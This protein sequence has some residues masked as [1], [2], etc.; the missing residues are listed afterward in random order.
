MSLFITWRHTVVKRGSRF[1][2][3]KYYTGILKKGLRKF[4][5]NVRGEIVFSAYMQGK[6]CCRLMFDEIVHLYNSF[7][8]YEVSPLHRG[9]VS[10]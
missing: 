5:I 8:Y 3:T 9:I 1:S 6:T 2:E 7:G 4:G 10:E